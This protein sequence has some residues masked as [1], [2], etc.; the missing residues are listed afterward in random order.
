MEAINNPF[1]QIADRLSVIENLLIDIKHKPASATERDVPT[2]GRVLDLE[3]FC[4]FTGFSRQHVYRLTSANKVP[5]SKRGKKLWFD[6]DMVESW[7]LENRRATNGE[8]AQQ[9]N[10]YLQSAA[11]RTRTR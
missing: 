1:Q 6:R 2:M 10:E 9:A 3:G 8:A 11:R 5:F 7:L 4:E